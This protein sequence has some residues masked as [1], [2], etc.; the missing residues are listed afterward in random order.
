VNAP[1]A[2]PPCSARSTVSGSRAVVALRLRAAAGFRGL[3][4]F[5]PDFVVL[6]MP[7]L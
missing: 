6:A 3:P 2:P 4:D 7:R 5:A 1:C